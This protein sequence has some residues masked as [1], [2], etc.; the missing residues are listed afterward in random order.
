MLEELTDKPRMNTL[1]QIHLRPNTRLHLNNCVHLL[2]RVR[3]FIARPHMRA[4]CVQVRQLACVR[5]YAFY[6]R[7]RTFTCFSAIRIRVHMCISALTRLRATALP[8]YFIAFT[9]YRFF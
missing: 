6:L 1:T 7:V 3:G 5:T 4:L 9:V 2:S 8:G